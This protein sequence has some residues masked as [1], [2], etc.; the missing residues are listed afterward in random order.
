M[1]IKV[2]KFKT[3]KNLR[4]TQFSA[5]KIRISIEKCSFPIG[6]L[7][8]S[9]EILFFNT[10]NYVFLRFLIVLNLFTLISIYR[11]FVLYCKTTVG[12]SQKPDFLKMLYK[13]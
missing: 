4:K 5:S 8:V 11:V 12:K 6:K 2:N 13:K 7:H 9:T 3:I 10:K 1:E